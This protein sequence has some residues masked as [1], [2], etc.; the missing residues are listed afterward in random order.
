MFL[1]LVLD[2]QIK[3]DLNQPVSL[4]KLLVTMMGEQE[5]FYQETLPKALND[6]TKIL[7]ETGTETFF[8]DQIFRNRYF[9]RDQILR[10]QK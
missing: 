6:N 10:N 1:L 4:V 9:F 3:D 5:H 2:D 8:R 7:T